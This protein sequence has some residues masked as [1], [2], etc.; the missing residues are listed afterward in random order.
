M[1]KTLLTALKVIVPVGFGI[2]LVWWVYKHLAPEEKEHLFKAFGQADYMWI[3]IS[4]IL[5]ILS[6]LSRAY[7]WKFLLE[8]LGLKPKFWNS[9]FA[10]MIG[11][12]MNLL[13]PRVGEVTR[14]GVMGRYNKM[15]FD[16]LFGTV[17]AER[18]ADMS[19]LLSLI[20]AVIISQFYVLRDTIAGMLNDN[21]VGEHLK[22]V[23]IVSIAVIVV[24]FPAL[25]LFLKKSQHTI[26]EKIRNIIR[27]F[28]D[29]LL[30]IFR[31]KNSGLFIMHTLMIWVLY[32]GM[33]YICFFSL[34]GTASTPFPGV[35]AAF[36]I[37]GLSI[38]LVQGGIGVYPAAVMGTLVLYGVAAGT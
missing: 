27:G 28:V 4:I 12:G 24:L 33:F 37:G 2:L 20:A 21:P 5:G 3:L 14:C 8:P 10:V 34:Q 31:M 7:R 29:G 26:A 15:P 11:Y 25:F 22:T 32:L 38:V 17:V 13:L 23:S 35:M 6:H 18:V 19:I 36:V 30:S 1:K 9:F 16:K